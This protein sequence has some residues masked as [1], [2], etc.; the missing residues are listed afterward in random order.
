MVSQ[1]LHGSYRSQMFFMKGVLKNFAIFTGKHLCWILFLRLQRR[2][3]PVNIA[4]FLRT[5]LFTEHLRW[6]LLSSLTLWEGKW[7]SLRR[8]M[9]YLKS[10][11]ML[12]DQKLLSNSDYVLLIWPQKCETCNLAYLISHCLL[13]NCLVQVLTLN[14][15]VG[16]AGKDNVV[17]IFRFI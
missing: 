12:I 1:P 14:V 8:S 7:Y 4:K 5:P 11:N 17:I 2:C 3:F 10:L 6:L 16:K 15:P 13:M 9:K